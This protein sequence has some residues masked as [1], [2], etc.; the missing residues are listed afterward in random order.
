MLLQWVPPG[1]SHM[2]LQQCCGRTTSLITS[3]SAEVSEDLYRILPAA[4][5]RSFA[6]PFALVKRMQ[7]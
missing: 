5:Y 2:R 4:S 6:E 1:R 7:P 3:P